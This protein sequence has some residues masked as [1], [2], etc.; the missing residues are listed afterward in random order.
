MR[1]TRSPNKPRLQQEVQ[2][3]PGEAAGSADAVGAQAPGAPA[4][5]SRVRYGRT[6][7]HLLKY[8]WGGALTPVPGKREAAAGGD[9]DQ[10]IVDMAWSDVEFPDEGLGEPP[11][12]PMAEGGVVAQPYAFISDHAFWELGP[13]QAAEIFDAAGDDTFSGHQPYAAATPFAEPQPAEAPSPDV[14]VHPVAAPAPAAEPTGFAWSQSYSVNLQFSAHSWFDAGVVSAK[15]ADIDAASKPEPDAFVPEE[16]EP[17]VVPESVKPKRRPAAVA[18]RQASTGGFELPPITFLMEPQQQPEAAVSV[19][20]LQQN[21]GLLEG[22]LEDFNVRG[23]IVQACPGP[24]VT[25][26]ELEPAPGTK[27]SRVIS[28]ADDIA[29]SMSAISARVAVVQGK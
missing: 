18:P 24:V 16:A 26:Y 4:T 28:L 17:E 20:T 10:P 6:P 13:G 14:S 25:L 2:V 1:F 29:R 3:E 23:D 11:I 27:S 8:V 15:P 5:P 9:F 19:E 7:D 21:A 12:E 22:V